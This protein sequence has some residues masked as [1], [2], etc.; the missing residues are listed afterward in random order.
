MQSRLAMRDRRCVWVVA[1]VGAAALLS[2]CVGEPHTFSA[3]KPIVLKV[4]TVRAPARPVAA[5]QARTL[6]P[7]AK[8]R[9]F[10]EFQQSQSQ[11]AQA[12]TVEGEATP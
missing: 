3:T 1:A 8:E 4:P 6:S 7:A 11:K 12:V 10:R 5:T 9:L 2:G